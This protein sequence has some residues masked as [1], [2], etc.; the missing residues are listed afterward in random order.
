MSRRGE[1]FCTSV[2]EF[3][4]TYVFPCAC[5]KTPSALSVLATLG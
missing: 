4:R 2:L 1:F 5:G 3:L